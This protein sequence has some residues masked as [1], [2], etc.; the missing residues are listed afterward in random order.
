[1]INIIK[2]KI[3]QNNTIKNTTEKYKNIHNMQNH[4]LIKSAIKSKNASIQ[5]AI[6]IKSNNLYSKIDNINKNKI[7]IMHHVKLSNSANQGTNI[8]INI[9]LHDIDNNLNNIIN[10]K[11]S[12]IKAN[13]DI[14]KNLNNIA[15]S[16]SVTKF[17][18]NIKKDILKFNSD[19]ISNNIIT[20]FCDI[21]Q[22]SISQ[23]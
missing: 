18:C 22:I 17:Q 9:I 6:Y 7:I 3:L 8:T 21:T 13:Y 15:N 10:S 1:M 4:T 5:P 14:N 2:N 12:Y 19:S 23:K 20:N 11:R 16:C